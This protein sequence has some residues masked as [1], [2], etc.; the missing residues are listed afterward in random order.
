[1]CED[2]G[3]PATN[4]VTYGDQPDEVCNLC[5]VCTAR[6]WREI[7]TLLVEEL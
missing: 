3:Q 6:L 7:Q 4:H 5:D 2:C 1:M